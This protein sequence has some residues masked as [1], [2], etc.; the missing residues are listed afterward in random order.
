MRGKY[1][2]T[3]KFDREEVG[4]LVAVAQGT[5]PSGDYKWITKL[6]QEEA[7]LELIERFSRLIGTLVNVCITG[8]VN[9]FSSYQKSFLRIW[10]GKAVTLDNVAIMLKKE[11]G[12]YSKEELMRIGYIALLQAI[13]RTKTNFSTTILTCYKD[14]LYEL[15]K[16]KDSHKTTEFQDYQKTEM[17]FEDK[18]TLQIDLARLTQ[19]EQDLV[20]D[21]LDE[22][23]EELPE[24]LCLKLRSILVD[25]E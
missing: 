7:K 9:Y 16:N 14:L 3:Q 10:A 8:R 22:K 15:I 1:K 18:I 4:D 24:D 25:S 21:F 2:S 13:D 17:T 19:E 5:E 6:S 11:L 23:I 20:E 12:T